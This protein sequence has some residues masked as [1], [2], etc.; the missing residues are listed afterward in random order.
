MRRRHG[1]QNTGLG[2][3]APEI[4]NCLKS[5]DKKMDELI[6]E[7]CKE[8][9]PLFFKRWGFVDAQ[10]REDEIQIGVEPSYQHDDFKIISINKDKEH[11]FITTGHAFEAW[12]SGQRSTTKNYWAYTY[13]SKFIKFIDKWHPKIYGRR[14]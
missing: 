6:K 2:N 4:F 8:A 12:G 5:G 11:S 7:M 3:P 9:C 13:K 14:K 1:G 10:F